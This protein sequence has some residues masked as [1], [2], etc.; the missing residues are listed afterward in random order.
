[1]TKT[2]G[3]NFDVNLSKISINSSSRGIPNNLALT[4]ESTGNSFIIPRGYVE[5]TDRK[6]RLVERGIINEQS[7]LIIQDTSQTLNTPLQTISPSTL[8]GRYKIT[9][10]YRYQGAQNY[11]IKTMYFNRGFYINPVIIYAVL[12][13]V[14]CLLLLYFIHRVLFK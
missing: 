3:N 8:N 13:G 11:S 14:V 9:A 10:Y 4:F 12:T 6:G 1:M 5:I 2:G 7:N